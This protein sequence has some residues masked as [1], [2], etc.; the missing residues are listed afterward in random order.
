MSKNKIHERIPQNNQLS[1]QTYGDVNYKVKVD[2]VDNDNTPPQ[3]NLLTGTFN[4]GKGGGDSGGHINGDVMHTDTY[5]KFIDIV[6]EGQIEGAVN[7]YNSIYLNGTPL[8][9]ENGN[10]N[11]KGVQVFPMY[12]TEDQQFPPMFQRSGA[13]YAINAEIKTN[14][15]YTFTVTDDSITSVNLLMKVPVLS[16]SD[17]KGNINGTSVEFQITVN[18][19][20]ITKQS[21]SGIA[22]SP[23]EKGFVINLADFQGDRTIVIQRTTPDSSD[24]K[25][26]NK[27]YI[28]AYTLLLDHT[29]NYANRAGCAIM[30]EAAQF[31]TQLPDR[32]YDLKGINTINIPENYDPINRTYTGH[33]NGI[34]KKAYT[35]NP[36]WCLYDL[37]TNTRYGAGDYIPLDK[38]N[39]FELYDMAAY[40][41]ELVVGLDGKLEPRFTFNC[42]ITQREQVLSIVKKIQGNFLAALFYV[43]GVIKIAQDKPEDPSQL[44]T[45]ANVIDGVFNYSTTE[46]D[47]QTNTVVVS[48][49]DPLND[50][51]LTTET[52]YNNVLLNQSGRQVKKE[53]N[54]F[55]CTSRS[56]AHRMGKYVLLTDIDNAETV[57][58][59][60]GLDHAKV[61]IGDIIE[62]HDNFMGNTISAG[63]IKSMDGLN[64]ELDREVTLLSGNAY[65]I[66]LLDQNGSVEEL[67]IDHS[68]VGT[69]S[70]ITLQDNKG[71]SATDFTIYAITQDGNDNYQG[72]LYRIMS[73][74]ENGLNMY[75]IT[76]NKYVSSK[77][78]NLYSGNPVDVIPEEPLP[79]LR[80]PEN[81]VLAQ[82]TLF[83]DGKNILND[84]NFS[85]NKVNG[86]THYEYQYRID[87][88]QFT[89]IERTNDRQVKIIAGDGVYD[90]RV[91]AVDLLNRSSKF[92]ETTSNIQSGDITPSDVTTFTIHRSG[93]TLTFS[94]DTVPL[95]EYGLIAYYEIR[96]GEHWYNALTVFKTLSN[97]YTY[98]LNTGGT[99][100]IKAVT[101]AGTYSINAA[102]YNAFP[103]DTNIYI[104]DNY[105][106]LGFPHSTAAQL[107]N[108]T[109]EQEV[110]EFSDGQDFNFS[111]GEV[112]SFTSAGSTRLLLS[113]FNYGAWNTLTET[114]DTYV[115]PWEGHINIGDTGFY[116]TDIKDLGGV[117]TVFIHAKAIQTYT[118]VDLY[119]PDFEGLYVPDLSESWYA[120][121]KEGVADM[122]VEMRYSEDGVNY[123]TFAEFIPGQ[124]QG[125]YFQYRIYLTSKVMN[126]RIYIEGFEV[127]YDIPD[128]IERS[129]I[130]TDS[131]G[132]IT[133][134]YTKNYHTTD[135]VVLG[136]PTDPNNNV[137]V[138]TLSK[139]L[140]Q[141]TF[142]S[143]NQTTGAPAP[144]VNIN[145]MIKGY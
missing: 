87:S 91:R 100:L 55:G 36:V 50:Y 15:D 14:Q 105:S 131:T 82:H 123:S 16:S 40:C 115:E 129:N 120:T 114:W 42:L 99:F 53:V 10:L 27:L 23:I 44:V 134:V 46:L 111:N 107:D 66:R 125:R 73:I 139:G 119:A 39:K 63:R 20:F 17:D 54:A 102:S 77:F 4:L 130:T 116:E 69:I 86:A 101:I 145:V 3:N 143:I 75:D 89:Q 133:Y 118:P 45:N 61:I 64:I 71:F 37:L 137:T 5:A 18:G 57:T 25:L 7:G 70:N 144:N 28:N 47:K 43:G 51:A 31:G 35:N 93:S 97:S 13:T 22:T 112:F 122:R 90:I 84:V 19:K 30:L 59:T 56:Q 109:V 128:V 138:K 8:A 9:D 113:K 58:Y 65:S 95:Q 98:T 38:L 72:E 34:F 21:I 1:S 62:I 121:G 110:F 140:T 83:K 52:V 67:K 127:E 108:F 132:K 117:E 2:Y 103:G 6:S 126:Y 94:W 12:G 33:W 79:L 26:Q 76:A 92:S 142:E 124:Y 48:Y 49:N 81:L 32:S 85:W 24:P 60:A 11:F 141:A 68:S 104:N 29:I 88:G 135:L 78:D 136:N 80:Y 96:Q 41:D 74:R 106:N